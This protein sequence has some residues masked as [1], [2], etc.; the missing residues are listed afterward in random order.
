MNVNLKML[1]LTKIMKD[2]DDWWFTVLEKTCPPQQKWYPKRNMHGISLFSPHFIPFISSPLAPIYPLN[3]L[4]NVITWWQYWHISH[5]TF[6]VLL[7]HS[8]PLEPFLS[9]FPI[10][11]PF[12]TQSNPLPCNQLLSLFS[13]FLAIS[14]S[15]VHHLTP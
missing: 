7:V 1:I 14:P 8:Y 9:F 13:I 2:Q 11:P 3:F 10:S 5:P 12:S 6:F 15:A 4:V